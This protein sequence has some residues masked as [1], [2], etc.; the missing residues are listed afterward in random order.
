MANQGK[1]LKKQAQ[2]L[3]AAQKLIVRFGFDKTTVEE[4]A[5]EAGVSK[6]AIYLCFPGKYAILDRLVEKESKRVLED[7][8]KHL[9]ADPH[10]YTIFNVYKYSVRAL[11]DNPFLAAMYTRDRKTLGE[12]G[13]RL[14][15]GDIRQAG[16]N[17][18][19]DFIRHFQQ[20]G[21]IDPN[22][23]PESL[24][25][26]MTALKYGLVEMTTAEMPP[27]KLTSTSELIGEMFQ[28]AFGRE[29]G[30]QATAQAAL[31]AS[32]AAGLSLLEQLQES[33]KQAYA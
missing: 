13:A 4:I 10:G 18:S 21:M 23:D 29:D 28:R 11:L 31:K 19:T 7:L 6:G 20:A 27:E 8:I 12:Y 25:Y 22:V 32:F 14:M 26:V 1:Q 24:G 30:D 16:M 9:D 33:Q 5:Q 15:S 3:D 2:I 17:F